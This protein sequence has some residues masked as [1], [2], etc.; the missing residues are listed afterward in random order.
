M[1]YF[2][3]EKVI[4]VI[5]AICYWDASVPFK[6]LTY[7]YTLE[8]VKK[9]SNRFIVQQ[10]R[11]K[12]FFYMFNRIALE[13]NNIPVFKVRLLDGIEIIDIQEVIEFIEFMLQGIGN[14]P[15]EV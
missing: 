12:E 10:V 14:G 3:I 5:R 4:K 1:E 8:L 9:I 6:E 13:S 11:T 2:E 7:E 15:I